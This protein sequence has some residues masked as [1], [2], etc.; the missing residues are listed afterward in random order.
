MKLLPFIGIV[1]LLAFA[2]SDASP[3]VAAAAPIACEALR[4]VPIANGTLISAESV[5]A[6]A[7]VPPT[8]ANPAAANPYTTLPAFCRVI[9]RLTPTPDSDIRVEVWLPLVGMES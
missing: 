7:F 6:G 1:G 3:R 2:A 8:H 5:E 9:A 4:Q